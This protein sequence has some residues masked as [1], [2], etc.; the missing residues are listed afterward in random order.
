MSYNIDTWTTK[1]CTLRI[2][3]P[4]V[5]AAID[6]DY[7]TGVY[8]NLATQAVFIEAAPE[9][10]EITATLEEGVVVVVQEISLWGESSGRFLDVLI[11][12]LEKST[13]QMRAV[14]IWEGGD[15]VER[16]IIENGAVSREEIDLD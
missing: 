1:A 13:G 9:C 10:F 8:C 5:L 3:L 4:A 12:I 16:L 6:N 14:L 15:S 2:P 7:I 11:P